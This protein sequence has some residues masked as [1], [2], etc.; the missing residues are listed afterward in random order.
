MWYTIGTLLCSLILYIFS[1]KRLQ[2]FLKCNY[3]YNTRTERRNRTH[4]A[5][6]VVKIK[7][8]WWSRNWSGGVLNNC[9]GASLIRGINNNIITGE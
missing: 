9:I 2:F 8:W 1:S 3:V 4:N 5:F 6:L 7:F